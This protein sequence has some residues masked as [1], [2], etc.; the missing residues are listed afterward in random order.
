MGTD[1][2]TVSKL[3]GH[4]H[5]KT[6]EIY[7]DLDNPRI[8]PV[9]EAIPWMRDKTTKG[10]RVV[11]FSKWRVLQDI[12]LIAIIQHADYYERN[13]FT[14]EVA[15]YFSDNLNKMGE[16]K[17]EIE[18]FTTY[19]ASEFAKEISHEYEYLISAAFTEQ[20][21]NKGFDGV[22]YPSVQLDGAGFNVALTPQVADTKIQLEVVE[23]CTA[24]KYFDKCCIDND[25]RAIL[26]PN[27]THFEF[28]KEYD[29]HAGTDI[30]LQQLGIKSIDDLN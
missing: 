12:R 2:Y 6:T 4:R 17:E 27:Q 1:I 26:Y 8:I 23:E 25:Y 5:L 30:C 29:Y 19:I 21:V 14:K 11:T 3:L 13:S 16:H 10:R 20:I 22:L 7:G 24:Y 9:Y 28:K 18:I 15:D